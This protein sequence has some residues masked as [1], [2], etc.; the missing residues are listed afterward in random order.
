V[1][2]HRCRPPGLEVAPIDA[3]ESALVAGLH[4]ES[5]PEDA[6]SPASLT[7]TLALPGNFGFLARCGGDP[8]GFVLA[9]VAADESE[10]LTIAVRP[11]A[12]RHGAGRALL[13]AALALAAG[14][15]AARAY[16]EVV[17][18]NVAALALYAAGGFRPCGR[19][20]GYYRQEGETPRPAIVLAREL[21]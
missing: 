11:D 7:E 17:E 6:W 10:I 15:G 21:P 14:L 9:R 2:D 16:L 20:E 3:C 8:L 12:R 18:D 19:R 5:F 4:A 1:T 13:D